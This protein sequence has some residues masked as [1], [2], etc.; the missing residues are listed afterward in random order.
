[1]QTWAGS[2]AAPGT[3]APAGLQS[4]KQAGEQAAA[5]DQAGD[6][7]VLLQSMTAAALA[8]PIKG[9]QAQCAGEIAVRAAAA[10]AMR[11]VKPNLA[12]HCLCSFVECQRFRIRARRPLHK[13]RR[14][15]SRLKS[16][17]LFDAGARRDEGVLR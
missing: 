5:V 6:F 10:A 4:G 15:D 16:L 2:G 8:E 12:G 13:R 9:R 14:R 1:M 11:E 3:R 7:D 17:A